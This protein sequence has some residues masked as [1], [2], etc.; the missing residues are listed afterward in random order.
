MRQLNINE[1]PNIKKKILSVFILIIVLVVF[2]IFVLYNNNILFPK[3]I[4]YGSSDSLQDKDI[5]N[6]NIIENNDQERKDD[7]FKIELALEKY[8]NENNLYPVGEN[9]VR[10]DDKNSK[11]YEAI[12]EYVQGDDLQD[13][14]DDYYYEYISDGSY[15]ELSARLG[16]LDDEDCEMMDENICIYKKRTYGKI[17]KVLTQN[18]KG[19]NFLEKIISIDT[20]NNTIIVTGNYLNDNDQ[21]VIK[22]LDSPEN[23]KIK[24]VKEITE[25]ERKTNNLILIGNVDS[26]DL[27]FN[28]YKKKIVIENLNL[29]NENNLYTAT[30]KSSQS[31]W[32]IQKD[33]F[34][35]ETGCLNGEISKETGNISVEK[36]GENYYH[37]LLN[38]D[39]DKFTLV[40]SNKYRA[41]QSF[42]KCILELN[43][44]DVEIYGY[45]KTCD[46]EKII[47]TDSI[48]VAS[49]DEIE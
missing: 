30:L 11:I 43:G 37:I 46:F 49:I 34:I 23:I 32:N 40:K 17:V 45:K 16:N 5:I 13:P 25:T 31:P 9:G 21:K 48:A 2:L 6:N 10:L 44:K 27:I 24:K 26:N 41:E 33:I 19:S 7:L 22:I 38:T 4:N 15:F 36:T 39:S 12:I 47:L 3:S 8:Y 28:V 18:E 1:D 35:I 42:L 29:V 14:D 20:D